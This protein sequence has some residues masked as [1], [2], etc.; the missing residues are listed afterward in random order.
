MRGLVVF[1]QNVGIANGATDGNKLMN[2]NC[3]CFGI[4][5]TP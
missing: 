1:L 4:I 3:D 2:A 5:T